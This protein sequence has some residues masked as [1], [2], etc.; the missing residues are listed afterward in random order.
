MGNTPFG[1]RTDDLQTRSDQDLR[2]NDPNT[3]TPDE[4]GGLTELDAL[5]SPSSRSRLPSLSFYNTTPSPSLQTAPKTFPDS[6]PPAFG[7]RGDSRLPDAPSPSIRNLLYTGHFTSQWA[8]RT[9]E[10]TI[11][12]LLTAIGPSDMALLLPSTFGLFCCLSSLLSLGAVGAY[13]DRSSR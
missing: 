9:W 4:S 5:L 6:A 8:E 1:R 13:I 12:L 7:K 2:S 3:L 10:F 11:I